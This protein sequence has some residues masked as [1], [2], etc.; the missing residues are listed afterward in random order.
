M[1]IYLRAFEPD[2]YLL[3]SEWRQDDEVTRSLGGNH[4]YVSMEREKQWVFDKSVNDNRNIYLAICLCEDKRMIG[5]TSLNN[6]DLR[7]LKAEWGGT[8]IGDK[9]MW[10]KG[11]ASEAARLMLDYIFNQYP[12][13]KCYAYCLE[14]HLVTVKM[15][16]S[17]GFII[18]GVSRDDVYKDGAFKSKI[19][20][21]ILRD[22]YLARYSDTVEVYKLV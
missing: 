21:S 15:F 12:I 8:I 14:E 1:R 13:H 17:L 16:K 11:I 2:D 3:I 4:Y 10:G 20:V 22:E 9:Q 6:I 5:Y 19:S 18:D 7:N